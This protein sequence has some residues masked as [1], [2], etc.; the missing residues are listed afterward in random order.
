M[1]VTMSGNYMFVRPG[2]KAFRVASNFT[3]YIELGAKGI[4]PYYL[5]GK[6]ESDEFVINAS[7]LD[8]RGKASCR[9]VDNFPQGPGCTKAMTPNGYRILSGSGELILAIEVNDE[10][11]LLM[12]TI[13]DPAGGSL[14]SMKTKTSWCFKVRL[15][16]ENQ[17][18]R[19][20]SFSID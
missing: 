14:P 11:C 3:N 12:G 15:Y 17:V 19:E 8:A 18:V 6:V 9:I 4:T 13:Y 7:L 16:S 20:V 5:E 1:S 2:E 10:I